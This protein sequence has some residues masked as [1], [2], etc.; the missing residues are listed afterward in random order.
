MAAV[1]T[2]A[3]LVRDPLWFPHRY[4]EANDSF[5][6]VHVPRAV[7]R[8]A[9]FLTDEFLPGYDRP[10]P[11][12]RLA[13]MAAGPTP[14]P[15]HFIFHSAYCCSTLLARAFD[16]DGISMGL[17]EPVL[18]ND[19]SG[20]K[21]RGAAPRDVAM[22]LDHGL[23]LLGRPFGPG[24]AVVVKPSNVV[25]VLAPAM[26]AMR[27]EARALLLYAPLPLYLAS[28]A[29]KGMWGRLWVREL[30]QRQLED[31]LVTYGFTPEDLFR[32]TDLQVA[33]VGWLVQ[34]GLYQRLS[35]RFGARVRTLDS[36]VLVER[37]REAMEKLASLFD[38]PLEGSAIDHIVATEFR[39]HSKLGGEY[40][41]AVRQGEQRESA[42]AHADEIAMVV[43]WAE[44]VA[45][46]AG[47]APA[48]GAALISA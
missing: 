9:S 16:R 37:P 21:R 45:A 31:G 44:E 41:A 10:I 39:R 34:H 38:L 2:A 12:G 40:D 8:S 48:L 7:H 27:P 36:E 32:Q 23:R 26:L 35:E 18:L 5:R 28:I 17:K 42:S 6:F 11:V 46:G 13:A 20:W 30:L 4:D 14:A 47:Q 19:V 29:K 1:P 24:E 15:I 25:N 22:V 33:A 3:E 43:R